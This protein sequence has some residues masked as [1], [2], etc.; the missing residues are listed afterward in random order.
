MFRPE[1]DMDAAILERGVKPRL[2]YHH[3]LSSFAAVL[4]YDHTA[5]YSAGLGSSNSWTN[6]SILSGTGSVMTTIADPGPP[7]DQR[8]YRLLR[9]PSP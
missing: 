9:Q 6:L 7:A 2:V 3:A 5:Q 1:V 4:G 8:Y